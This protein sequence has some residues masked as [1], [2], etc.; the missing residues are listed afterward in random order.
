MKFKPEKV[1]GHI[2]AG[3][4]RG[5]IL[6]GNADNDKKYFWFKIEVEGMEERLNISILFDSV[7]FNKYASYFEDES[8]EVDTDDFVGTPVKFTVSDKQVGNTIYSKFTALDPVMDDE[9]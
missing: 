5:A 8:K 4:Y 7:L 9:D 2:P 6:S 3:N 1:T